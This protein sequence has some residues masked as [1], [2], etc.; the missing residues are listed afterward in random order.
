MVVCVGSLADFDNLLHAYRAEIVLGEK[1]YKLWKEDDG[2]RRL[3][4]FLPDEFCPSII[5]RFHRASVLFKSL[6]PT[7]GES[8][9][10][11]IFNLMPRFVR[12][13]A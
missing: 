1:T 13:I 3:E 12:G 8:D 4:I 7:V 6:P 5:K 10:W 11:K 9:K 2:T